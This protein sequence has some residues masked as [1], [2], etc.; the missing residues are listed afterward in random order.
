[1][2]MILA[3]AAAIAEDR[4]YGYDIVNADFYFMA[5]LSGDVH[6]TRS[7]DSVTTRQAKIDTWIGN[8]HDSASQSC[9]CP[10]IHEH[11]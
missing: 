8:A 1:M 10:L 4:D 2:S 9:S 11:L 5:R 6:T 3:E 7:Y